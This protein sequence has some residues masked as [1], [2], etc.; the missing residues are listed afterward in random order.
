LQSQISDGGKH[1]QAAA[2]DGRLTAVLA[3]SMSANAADLGAQPGVYT[4]PP[5]F[6]WTG[7]YI[8]GNFGGAWNHQNVTDSLFGLSFSNASN[9]GAFMGGGQVG[10]NYQF[11]NIVLGVEWD[12]DWVGNN[13]N[14]N[15][16][17]GVPGIG[18]LQV[19]SINGWITTL[20]ARFGVTYR[21]PAVPSSHCSSAA[22]E[23]ERWAPTQV[24]PI[25]RIA[26]AQ[27]AS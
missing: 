27:V 5:L 8:G 16:G 7:F 6:S 1:A 17:I 18:P 10:F 12:I 24:L 20:A 13:D 2:D 9:D 4:P 11:S 21:L 26:D 25:M 15:S 22:I 23:G 19:S 3:F 14:T